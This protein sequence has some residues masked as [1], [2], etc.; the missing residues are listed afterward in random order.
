MAPPL[1]KKARSES[2]LKR[3]YY[4][5]TQTESYGGVGALHHASGTSSKKVKRWLWEPDTYT[6]HK[7]TRR[8]FN[9]RRVVVGGINQ[10]W[11]AALV[12]I[13]RLKQHN[14]ARWQ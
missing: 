9:C 7:R 2:I 8:R 10:Q 4:D 6:L 1:G 14:A 13:A 5:T 3:I 11:Q 12:D